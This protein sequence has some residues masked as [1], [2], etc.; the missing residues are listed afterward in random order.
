MKRIYDLFDCIR[1][2]GIYDG[3]RYWRFQSRAKSDPTF[4]IN[5]ETN[6]RRA[7]HLKRLRGELLQADQL[8]HFA[9]ILKSQRTTK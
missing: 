6:I 5:W 9:D 1:K 7:A 4:T 3:W 8:T 2:L